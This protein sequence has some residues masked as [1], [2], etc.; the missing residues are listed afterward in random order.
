[1]LDSATLP[2]HP[3]SPAAPALSADVPLVVGFN[4]TE[5]TLFLANDKE[6]FELDEAGLQ[7]RVGRLLRD[8]GS[9]AIERM[10]DL[11]PNDSPSDLY[12]AIHTGFLRYPIDSIRIAERKA[13]QG[14][15]P[16]YA[17]TFEWQSPARW[18]RLKTPHALEIPFVFDNAGLGPWATFTRSTPEAFALAARV[19]STW[20]AFARAGDP[21]TGDLPRWEPYSA[22]ERKTML[23]DNE[24]TIVSDPRPEERKLWESLYPG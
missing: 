16:A 18:G 19:S 20:A 13:A 21:N 22:S 12:I 15:G 4:R 14:G 11:Y 24:S 3:F 7:K 10:R 9:E 1:V 2:D 23:I 8:R 17:Y 6:A 5:A